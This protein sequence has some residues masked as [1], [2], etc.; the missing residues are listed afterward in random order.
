MRRLRKILLWTLGVVATPL[1]LLAAAALWFVFLAGPGTWNGAMQL[2]LRQAS[3]PGELE[4]AGHGLRR[5]ADG[6]V[7]LDHLELADGEGV[8]LMLD[9]AA[10]DWRFGDLLSGALT[11]ERVAARRIE[12]RRPPAGA[13]APEEEPASGPFLESFEWPRAPL[14][15]R[16][17]SLEVGELALGPGMVPQPMAFTVGARVSDVGDEQSLQLSVEPLGEAERFVRAGAELDFARRQASIDVDMD[18]PLI[19]PAASALGVPAS[20][21]AILTVTGGGPFGQA[22]LEIS[23]TVQGVADL[24][25]TLGLGAGAD[26]S[27]SVEADGLVNFVPQ[28]PVPVELTGNVAQFKIGADGPDE[29]NLNLRR[30]ELTLPHTTVDATGNYAA[31]TST[32]GLDA[33]VE[34]TYH[35]GLDPYLSGARFEHATVTARLRGAID[36]LA[37][38]VQANLVG[39]S[40]ERY[41]AAAVALRSSARLRPD[42]TGGRAELIVQSPALGDPELDRLLG[43]TPTLSAQFDVAPDRAKVRN[44]VLT[45]AALG[46]TGRL[47][48]PLPDPVVDGELEVS[49][50]DLA[51]GPLKQ[52][53]HGGRGDIRVRLAK[54]APSGGG[55]LRLDGELTALDFADPALGELVGRR[56]SLDLEAVPG[57]APQAELALAAEQGLKVNAL[58]RLAKAGGLDGR[59]AVTLPK[60]PQGLVP[61]EIAVGGPADLE[62]RLAGTIEKPLT[63]GTLKLASLTAAAYRFEAPAL[64]YDLRDLATAPAGDIAFKTSMQGEALNLDV[65]FAAAEDFSGV[66]LP[67]LAVDFAGLS[68]NG[69]GTVGLQTPSYRLTADL[70]TEAL[71]RLAGLFGAPVDGRMDGTLALSPA[72]GDHRATVELTGRELTVNG[73]AVRIADAHA[74][75]ALDQIMTG[76]LGLSGALE[77]GRIAAGEATIQRVGAKLGGTAL[78]PEA[79]VSVNLEAPARAEL[80]TAFAADVANEEGPRIDVASLELRSQDRELRAAGPF[81]VT[82]G[83]AITLEGLR[84]V[85]S[86]GGEL[87]ADARYGPDAIRA[88]V[89]VAALPLGPLAALGGV[90]D[91]GGRL[92]LDATV[93]TAAQGEKARLA[94]RAGG[95]EMPAA[96]EG[97]RFDLA[98]DSVW[99]GSEARSDLKLEGPF[100]RPLTAAL[101]VPLR[102]PPGEVLPT[103]STDGPIKGRVDWEGDVGDLLALLPESDHVARGRTRV[104]VGVGGTVGDPRLNGEV[105]IDNGRYENLM[106]GTILQ[107]LALGVTF[108]E[109]GA[110]TLQLSALGPDGAG[111]ITGTGDARLIG[112]GK[113]GKA[114]IKVSQL[115]AVNRDEARAVLDGTTTAD[116]NGKRLDIVS[117]M[118]LQE[119]EVRLVTDNLP[120]DVV[121][122]ELER[123][124]TA[125]EK[126]AA[127][128]P[129]KPLPI[130]LDVQVD[131]PRRFF[132]R[133]RGLDSEWGGKVTVKGQLPDPKIKVDFGVLR[134][135]LSLLGKD[136]SVERGALGVRD[137]LEPTFEITLVRETPDLVGR[138][139]IAGNP[140][141]PKIT[142]S[143]EPE[144]P[145][146][147]VL[148]RLFFDKSQQSLTPLEALQLAQGIETLTNGRAG[149][150]DRFREAVGLDVLRVE[151]GET[152]DSAGAVSAGRYVS[153]DVYVGAKQSLDSSAGSVVVEIDVLPNVKVDAEVGSE[154]DT[155][156]GIN[157]E[158]RY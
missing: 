142:F 10:V 58:V 61:A 72:G 143:S 125:E 146:D 75:I 3:T 95:L 109:D 106:S 123:D 48:T 56:L 138:I 149:M 87:T 79:D 84:L 7:R 15:V 52:A 152:A 16:L 88:D 140:S 73:D 11:L 14:P 98:F 40:F 93:D 126:Q 34:A 22:N 134:G 112:P 136:F 45:A 133:G 104:A 36:D 30:L 9:D 127:G 101:S 35:D 67:R 68:V 120:P 1:L 41:H 50:P 118:V 103:P 139:N 65:A 6:V 145:S 92:D 4:I 57:E 132:V 116:W 83:E 8:W 108:A 96:I 137:N 2:A 129:A 100:E 151:E 64:T 37:A 66:E 89:K 38:D 110:G 23:A 20:N 157:W 124:K 105:R 121:A 63:R 49:A 122:I 71:G 59:Y 5:D 99:D 32:L 24:A 21:R 39:P 91:V 25:A 148:P 85:T 81:A 26:G 94:V 150:T 111:R 69:R 27:W 82:A 86:F 42:G 155:S 51:I 17:E 97:A 18:M 70:Q 13:P 74:E 54:L 90:E 144:L 62:G 55:S 29:E 153:E 60:L 113:G 47:S 107:D 80:R 77:V 154:G 76:G 53:L 147:E 31:A 33:T 114:E 131:A 46:V 119:T 158:Y 115:L 130:H 19:E 28:G 141:Q 43:G 78:K 44:I 117:R 128:K 102:A 12:V 135:H 156:T